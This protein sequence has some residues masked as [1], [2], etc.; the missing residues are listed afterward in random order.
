MA[1]TQ[2]ASGLPKP[3][4]AK[5]AANVGRSDLTPGRESPNERHTSRKA[6][7]DAAVQATGP[8]IVGHNTTP[9]MVVRR[10]GSKEAEST[11][12]ATVANLQQLHIASGGPNLVV[13]GSG[14]ASL[15][16]SSSGINQSSISG[17]SNRPDS[18]SDL[19][20]KPPSLDGKSI[21][22]G[23]TFALDE[24]E[25]LRPDD[26]A[27]VKAAAEDDDTGSLLAGSRIGSEAAARARGSA[28]ADLRHP[29]A[30]LGGQSQGIMTP[31]SASSEQPPDGNSGD[32]LN[33]IY[34]QAP[35]DKLL[36]ALATPRDRY[37]LLRL[38]KD[39]MDFVQNS[40][41]PYMDLPPSN[42][43]CRMLTH[44]L[45]DYYHMTH[46]YEPHIGSV[47]IFRTPFCRV[48][49]SLALM[50]PE[51]SAST[52][53]TP[54]P[55]VLPRK[56]MRR[57]QEGD[58]GPT[59]T[60]PSKAAS[61]AGSE[62]KDAKEKTSASNPKL[63]RE[64]REEM[65]KLARERI[66]GNSEEASPDTEGATGMS[67]TSSISA[68]RSTI[69]KKGRQVKQ[70][71]DDSDGFD[72]RHQYT[73]Y[74]G[75]QQQTWVPQ[76][77]V[78]A[79][80]PSPTAQYPSQT[81]VYIG[82]SPPVYGQQAQSYPGAPATA[83]PPAFGAYPSVQYAPQAPQQ[84][85]PPAGSPM[86]PYVAPMPTG[87]PQAAWPV[88][89][90]AG[91]PVTYPARGQAPVAAGAGAIPYPYG[92]LPAHANPNDPK[93]QHPIPGSYNRNHG[94]N[95]MTQSFIPTGSMQQTPQPPFTTPGS[96]HSS[97]QIGT[98]HLAYAGYQQAVA[99]PYGGTYGM[100]RQGSNNSVPSYHS[101]QQ[102]TP[103]FPSMPAIPHGSHPHPA[104]SHPSGAVPNR[105][106]VPQGPSSQMYT[107]LPNYGNPAT[108]PQ[109][110][111]TGM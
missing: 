63:S 110:P 25:S 61:E 65:Y 47:R 13:D 54:P 17:D 87:A 34:R 45:A 19:E 101:P 107:N 10:T 55:A 92:Q 78:Q 104:S 50:V 95:P 106:P 33:V 20:H 84:P 86:A 73:P 89:S 90:Y 46:S 52:S 100:V 94:F 7:A 29:H 27:S 38:E 8:I 111:A 2:I 80:Y 40:K 12:D 96:H 42:S 9:G 91:S 59:S 74:W 71:R 14:L 15:T 81:P 49:P 58:S 60:S 26:S 43:F 72:S 16:P 66:F 24:K 68:N 44:K 69:S 6:T 53:S 22:S 11:M 3:S 97:P 109:R 82:P 35:D 88:S 23:T 64:Q 98:P 32:A 30:A 5:I 99:I 102:G 37:F 85:F 4:F 41:E 75:P 36:D 70:R 31:Q 62:L 39:V 93:S 48:P 79:Q 18:V 56:I 51:M 1:S 28:V 57:G 103:P 83:Q 67:R 77:Q 76:P 108:L 21:A 105:P